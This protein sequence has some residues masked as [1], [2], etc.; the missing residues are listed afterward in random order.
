V[1]CATLKAAPDDAAGQT[2]QLLWGEGFTVYE[3]AAGWAWG[4][5]QTDGYVGYV[6][7]A[8]LDACVVEPSH[9]VTALRSFVYP[10]PDLKAPP[11]DV[12]S[13]TSPVT[14]MLEQ[15]G[16]AAIAGGGWVFAGHLTPWAQTEPDF[17]A[18]AGRL[19]GIPYLWGGRTSLG[20]DCSALVQLSLAAA[21]LPA[22]RDSDMQRNELGQLHGPLVTAD[23]TTDAELRRG[24][25]VFFPGHVGLMID[26]VQLIH[27]TAF[28]MSVTIEPLVAVVS[29]TDQTRGG[30]LLAVRRL[31]VTSRR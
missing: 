15:D 29:R 11:R 6:R 19:L 30:G 25:L 20:L 9:R 23:A 4:Q 16:Y 27:A 24:D 28:T 31:D 5:N 7:A 2:S 17:V 26:G 18:T 21:G 8:C 22:P 13:L 12:L 10:R 1:G 3:E 14:V